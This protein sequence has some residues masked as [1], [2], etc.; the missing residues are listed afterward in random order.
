MRYA[1]TRYLD[2]AVNMIWH[3]NKFVQFNIISY[4]Y[5][6]FP[7]IVCNFPILIHYHYPIFNMPK[8]TCPVMATNGYEIQSRLCIIISFQ[9]NTAAVMF[10]RVIAYVL[11]FVVALCLWHKV[12]YHYIF[13][14]IYTLLVQKAGFRF[15]PY[16]GRLLRSIG[17]GR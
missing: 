11:V 6:I 15:L 1:P 16:R 12:F 5:C 10:G 8:Y 13:P 2:D 7:M 3:Y 4:F 14:L 17:R 9:T